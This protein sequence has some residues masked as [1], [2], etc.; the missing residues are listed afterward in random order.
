MHSINTDR[1]KYI[2]TQRELMT[3][4]GSTND[5]FPIQKQT[6]QIIKRWTPEV[7][8]L[9]RGEVGISDQCYSEIPNKILQPDLVTLAC[10]SVTQEAEPKGL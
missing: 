7:S 1:Y 3:C 6:N 4:F 9:A 2:A 8:T 10:E 5:S